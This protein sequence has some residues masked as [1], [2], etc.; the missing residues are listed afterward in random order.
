MG[1]PYIQRLYLDQ[2]R[3]IYLPVPVADDQRIVLHFHLLAGS[4]LHTPEKH[5]EN[6]HHRVCQRKGHGE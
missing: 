1:E 3:G 5:G 2:A 6:A 4:V